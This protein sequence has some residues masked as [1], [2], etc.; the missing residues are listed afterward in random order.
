MKIKSI[1]IILPAYL[2]LFILAIPAIAW[3]CEGPPPGECYKCRDGIWIPYGNCWSGCPDCTYCDDCWCLPYGNCWF[4]CSDCE[5]C[6]NCWCICTSQCCDD[7]DC[8]WCF[9]CVDCVCKFNCAYVN[10]CPAGWFCCDQLTCYNP[11]THKCCYDGTGRICGINDKC[12]DDGTCGLCCWTLEELPPQQ[13][14]DCYCMWSS[15]SCSDGVI[16]TQYHNCKRSAS[17]YTDCGLFNNV[18]VGWHWGCTEGEDLCGVIACWLLNTEICF[19]VCDAAI[20]ACGAMCTGMGDPQACT[21]ALMDCQN[22]L[23]YDEGIDCGC[24]TIK[25]TI[26]DE[27][28]AIFGSDY[29]CYGGSCE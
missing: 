2:M 27:P 8:L 20:L 28:E 10:C 7:Y 26:W 17:G 11:A 24:L 1:N 14:G 9:E 4:G 22:C 16:R 23:F 12:C 13:A 15:G 18:Q 21:Q 5:T 19:F 3:E 6:I 29:R 25:C